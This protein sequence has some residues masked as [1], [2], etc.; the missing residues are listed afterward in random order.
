MCIIKKCSRAT[1]LDNCLVL[2]IETIKNYVHIKRSSRPA[3]VAW[4]V[5]E[6]NSHSV[7]FAPLHSVD[8]ILSKH[9]VLIVQLGAMT[10]EVQTLEALTLEVFSKKLCRNSN[11]RTPG[12]FAFYNT[13]LRR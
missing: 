3:V 2:R 12:S 1:S 9:G 7:K 6:S 10:L 4:I 11:C 5:K 8:R 13:C